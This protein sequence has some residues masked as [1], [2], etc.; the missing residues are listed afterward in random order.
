MDREIL[1]GVRT[2]LFDDMLTDHGYKVGA[3]KYKEKVKVNS[4][5]VDGEISKVEATISNGEA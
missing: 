4:I 2:D 1:L 3:L 5:E